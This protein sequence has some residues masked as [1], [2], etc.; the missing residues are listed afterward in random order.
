MR[1]SLLFLPGN[2]PVMLQNGAV[3]PA[4]ALIMDLEDAVAPDQKD[5]ARLLVTSAL[6][7]LDYSQEIIIRINAPDSGHWQQDLSAIAPCRP[8]AVMTTKSS[9]GAVKQT[10]ELLT[11]LEQ[12]NQ[13]VT[14]T[15]GIIALI[16][17]A[18]GVEQAYEIAT[19]SERV[20]A[21]FLGAEDLAA[22]LQCERTK[23][24]AEIFY[25]RSRLVLAARAAGVDAIDTPFT[26]V[27]DDEGMITDAELARSLGFSGKAAI[28]P[29]H[30][31]AINQ[32]F[33]PR[34]EAI[35]YALAVKAALEQGKREGKGA[36][37]LDGKMIDAPIAARAEQ[38]LIAAGKLRLLPEQECGMS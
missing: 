25:S 29:R 11:E 21:L 12:A 24:G 28:S 23:E 15:I 16:E 18:L 27:Q 3:M 35:R 37:S 22:D 31:S 6:R 10:A 32:V 26:D 5:A 1:R 2:S 34:P 38:V 13:I 33:S 7:S 36:V 17:T 14:G 30:L 20:S 4:D 9:V 19:A 8:D